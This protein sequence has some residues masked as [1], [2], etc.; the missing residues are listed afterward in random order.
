MPAAYDAIAAAMNTLSSLRTPLLLRRSLTMLS[1]FHDFFHFRLPDY[2]RDAIL[3]P[4]R[5]AD[6]CFVYYA[7]A[8]APDECRFSPAPPQRLLMLLRRKS[9]PRC[10]HRYYCQRYDTPLFYAADAITPHCR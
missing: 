8:T 6:S 1:L 2:S 10:R 9:P 4:L 3:M 5:Y 7:G